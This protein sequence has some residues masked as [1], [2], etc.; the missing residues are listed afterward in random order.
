[1]DFEEEELFPRLQAALDSNQLD[2]LTTAVE[3]AHETETGTRR[4]VL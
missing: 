3:K 2:R 4:D 1:M